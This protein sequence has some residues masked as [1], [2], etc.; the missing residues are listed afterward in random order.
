M[1]G[2]G[3]DIIEIERVKHHSNNKAF[4]EKIFTEKEI[5]Y[6]KSKKDFVSHLATTFAGKEAVFKA[7]GTG[8]TDGKEIE[9]LRNKA[10]VPKAKVHGKLKNKL[11][12]KKIRLSLSYTK[13]YAVA[14][15]VIFS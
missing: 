7:L 9:I 4:I 1:K 2:I 13:D 3:T 6:A 11:K 14:F 5:R 15:A 12:E 8:W 10:G